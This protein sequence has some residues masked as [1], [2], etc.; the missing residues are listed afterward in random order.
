M[1]NKKIRILIPIRYPVGGI[2]T[3]LKY[4]YG[5]IDNNKYRLDFVAP[6]REWLERIKK[7]LSKFKI[8]VHPTGLNSPDIKLLVKIIKLLNSKQYQIIHSQG[9]TAGILSNLSNLAYKI[10][11]IITLHHVFGHGQFSDTFWENYGQVKRKILQFSLSFADKIQ[12]VS[13]D[14]M[15]NMLQNFPGL[16]R[17]RRKIITIRNGI[18][19]DEFQNLTEPETMPF[20]KEDGYI[21]LG[22]LGRYMPEK[23]F[24]VIIDAIE[25]LVKNYGK[26]NYRVVTVGGFG[27]FIR[28]YR[29][30]INR[31]GINDYFIFLDFIQ[32]IAP[33][34]NMF[35]V[36]LI[37]S[38]G[39]ACGLVPMEG[40]VCGVP[41]VAF[42]CIG[43]R[44]VLRFTPAKLVNVG[45]TEGFV[46]EIIK[47]SE[48]LKETKKEFKEYI[49][50]AIYRYSAET[51]AKKLDSVFYELLNKQRF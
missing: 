13:Q 7:D 48:S 15:E 40:L 39:E 11:H 4:T 37:P 16:A 50:K 27:G 25:K 44:E 45:D 9:Y 3:Y 6:S 5:K 38:L 31:R 43:L 26:N 1:H 36:L 47:I 10:P 35:D 29:H 19:V 14:S 42:S 41:I 20:K 32:N 22:F 34:I 23:G 21:Y 17:K 49:P 30:D 28:E 2:R 24:L 18:D 12:A 33:V 46:K 51:T 8:I